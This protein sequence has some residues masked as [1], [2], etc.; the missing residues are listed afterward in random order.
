MVLEHGEQLAAL[1]YL[2]TAQ[3]SATQ[4]GPTLSRTNTPRA[5]AVP[6][7]LS[8]PFA[9][10]G[11]SPGPGTSSSSGS[12]ASCARRVLWELMK[13]AAHTLQA[14]PGVAATPRPLSSPFTNT[15][16]LTTPSPYPAPASASASLYT[17]T[18]APGRG[19]GYTPGYSGIALGLGQA[20]GGDPGALFFS[21]ASA[22]VQALFAAAQRC[23]PGLLVR[24]AAAV[25]G[26]EGGAGVEMAA[27]GAPTLALGAGER[28][29]AALEVCGILL[30]SLE[31]A[32]EEREEKAEWYPE[33]ASS[34]AAAAAQP[35]AEA[36]AGA[37]L[38]P[39]WTAPSVRVGLAALTAVIDS[40]K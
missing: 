21:R 22:A 29:E 26:A 16:G 28:L 24:S 12:G 34:A 25:E 40:L 23:A 17:P 7:P 5:V 39:W 10:A 1:V 38:A 36:V 35:G 18:P 6:D 2:R 14:P 15:P 37:P 33:Y 11:K 9:S 31:A 4:Q 13:S 3:S 30:G 19:A 8:S 20:P 27:S 32:A